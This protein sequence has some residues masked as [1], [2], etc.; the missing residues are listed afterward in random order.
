VKP[1]IDPE[2]FF[3]WAIVAIGAAV[4]LGMVASNVLQSAFGN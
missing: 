3:V 2:L 1:R 4:C